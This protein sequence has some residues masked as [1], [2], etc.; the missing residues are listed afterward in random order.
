MLVRGF[1]WSK[2]F[3]TEAF[4][5]DGD[6]GVET[7]YCAEVDRVQSYLHDETQEDA[8]DWYLFSRVYFAEYIREWKTTVSSECVLEIY[9]SA[10]LDIV[11]RIDLQLHDH[12]QQLVKSPRKTVS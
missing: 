1:V 8:V 2:V 5:G 3:L 4:C 11:K 10:K 7:C 6:D 12:L 9:L